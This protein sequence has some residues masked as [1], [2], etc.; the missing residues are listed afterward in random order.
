MNVSLVSQR[1]ATDPAT[2]AKQTAAAKTGKAAIASPP[3][4]SQTRRAYEEIK[5][6]ILD[7]EMPPGMQAL[8]QEVAQLLGMSRTPVREALIRL[9]QEGMVEVRPRHGMRVLPLSLAD[10]REI[11][12]ILAALEATAA[13]IIAQRGLSEAELAQ[14]E[15]AAADMEA[16]LARNDLNAWADGDARF[17]CLLVELSHN[18][19]LQGMVEAVRDQSHRARMATLRIRPKPVLSNAEHAAVIEAIRSRDA[20]AAHRLHRAHRLRAAD[21][22]LALLQRHG[23]DQL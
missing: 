20:E 18:K 6:R 8:E 10:L 16:A 5:R 4:L 22:V 14:L 19:R 15:T 3:R 17:H 11:Y 21:L 13:E 23:L 7:N 1:P 2:E 9:A 12:D